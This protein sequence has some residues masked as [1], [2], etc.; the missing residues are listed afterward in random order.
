MTPKETQDAVD[1][2]FAK[3][4]GFQN[5]FL[6]INIGLKPRLK[7]SVSDIPAED[8]KDI[9]ASLMKEGVV[10]PNDNDILRRYLR[11]RR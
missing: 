5:T 6:G 4:T 9:K 1:A 10:A 2:I 7:A 3:D 11:G 8:L